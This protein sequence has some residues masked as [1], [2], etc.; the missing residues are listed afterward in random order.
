MKKLFSALLV[1]CVL[2]LAGCGEATPQSTPSSGELSEPSNT[3][4]PPDSEKQEISDN[5]KPEISD[6]E[7]PEI[8]DGESAQNVA[9]ADTEWAAYDGYGVTMEYP[10]TWTLYCYNEMASAAEYSVLMVSEAEDIFLRCYVT[11]SDP[12]PVI[13]LS[14]SEN[15]EAKLFYDYVLET[16]IRA[17][18]FPIMDPAAAMEGDEAAI[19]FI[20]ALE[21]YN[22]NPK[23]PLPEYTGELP[24]GQ[25]DAID[26]VHL[27]DDG[28]LASVQD[29]DTGL[30]GYVDKTGAWR[31]EPQFQ[32]A[33][34]FSDGRAMVQF[35]DDSWAYIDRTGALVISEVC[36]AD[37]NAYPLKSSVKFRE[38]IAAVNLQTESDYDMIYI[39]VDGNVLFDATH[40][41]K[42]TGVGYGSTY[43][44]GFASNFTNGKAVAARRVNQEIDEWSDSEDAP[45]IIDTNGNILA[46]IPK[47]YYA[48]TN[49]F[50][51]NMMVKI[52]PGG[53]F[54]GAD[55]Y[56][57][58]DENGNVVVPCE[59]PYLQ[60]CENGWY[61]VQNQEGRYGYID[62]NGSVMI[63]FEFEDAEKFSSGLAAVLVDGLWG[64]IN[65]EGEMA[66]E[67]TYLVASVAT[68]NTDPYV[69]S[70][71]FWDGVGKVKDGDRWVL[72][73]TQGN[74]IVDDSGISN[75][76][77]CGSGLIAYQ[78]ANTE[79]WG[80]MTI[81]G[82]I[83]IEARF[84]SADTFFA[85]D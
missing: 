13:I 76:Y 73:D 2:F 48:D 23:N 68:I 24:Q 84:L 19:E 35:E 75:F 10:S 60:Y 27:S 83:A 15:A 78:D 45:V 85:A 54:H 52:K 56:G 80:Y 81:G 51:P 49:G 50:D 18:D 74:A 34:G 8:S 17:E 3:Q 55:L 70:C 65:E 69:G 28:S 66:I 21:A 30:F 4:Q 14:P 46:T 53:P 64:F 72:I 6:S 5:E 31:I 29:A 82:E 33:F 9:F 26:A 7:K 57:L 79:L 16:A 61:V 44:F 71:T 59:Y 58:C 77:S 62:K 25:S 67:P 47:E 41:P 36:D 37:G 42:V 32:N 43:F 40:L 22:A 20:T 1:F 11:E 63:D 12:L 39:D 38:G